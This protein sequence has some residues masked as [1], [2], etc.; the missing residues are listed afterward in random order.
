MIA[1]ERSNAQVCCVAAWDK[2]AG[3]VSPS[4]D[5][6][7]NVLLEERLGEDDRTC[8]ED[9]L[10]AKAQT[11]LQ[12]FILIEDSAFAS[13]SDAASDELAVFSRAL[14]EALEHYRR[15]VSRQVETLQQR[16]GRLAACWL[17]ETAFVSSVTQMVMHP[18]YQQII[19]MGNC[20]ITMLLQELE[21][22][23]NHWFWAL[24]AITGFD[25]I[26]PRDRGNVVRMA[27]A[28]IQWGKAQGYL[29]Q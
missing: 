24:Q 22:E 21:R 28:W 7:W 4:A 5:P 1:L 26:A 6:A 12:E 2:L 23:P 27:E 17:E 29:K 13:V 16:F 9:F 8:A 3:N 18:A 10:R 14:N 19:G 20:A 25:P 15:P 11:G